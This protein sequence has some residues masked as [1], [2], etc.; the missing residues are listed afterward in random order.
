MEASMADMSSDAAENFLSALSSI[1]KVAGPALQRFGPG[2]AQGAAKGASVGGPW[3]AL[4]GAGTGLASGVLGSQAKPPAAPPAPR[5]PA[6]GVP[7]SQLAPAAP[8]ATPSLPTGQS[9]AGTLLS[10]LQNPT[11]QQAL[12]SQVLGASGTPQVVTPSGTSVPRAAINSLLTQLLANA[13][14]GLPESEETAEQSYLQGADGEYL[15]DP[16]SVEQ[17]AALVLSHF[18]QPP[19]DSLP[20]ESWSD[21]GSHDEAVEFY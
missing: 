9:A 5:A 3:G 14:E 21:A 18:A 4:I 13:T 17:Q 1:G 7:P 2:V 12:M 11:I 10:L 6:V 16:A 20:F 19:G 15:V 8:L